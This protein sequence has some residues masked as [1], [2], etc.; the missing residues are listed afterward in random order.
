[1]ERIQRDVALPTR[2]RRV[3]VKLD[4]AGH[5]RGSGKMPSIGVHDDGTGDGIHTSAIGSH[6]SG[7]F[8]AKALGIGNCG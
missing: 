5:T 8:T 2:L 6:G 3:M 7:P 4:A 1:M